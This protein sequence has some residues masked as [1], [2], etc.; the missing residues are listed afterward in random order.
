M[1]ANKGAG[2]DFEQPIMVLDQKIAEMKAFAVENG[3]DID[4]ELV[5]LEK[6][7]QQ[8]LSRVRQKMSPWNRVEIAR[9]PGELHCGQCMHGNPGGADRVALSLE[10][11]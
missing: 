5:R 3:L 8:L 6:K 4:A 2:L 1:N 7:R 10:P 9:R 11:A